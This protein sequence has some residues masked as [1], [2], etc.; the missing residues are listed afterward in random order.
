MDSL[1]LSTVVAFRLPCFGRTHGG[2]VSPPPGLGAAGDAF[3]EGAPNVGLCG[4]FEEFIIKKMVK[5][6][7]DQWLIDGF[8]MA[9]YG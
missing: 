9:N 4:L 7:M 1:Q 2:F 6:T 3:A 5:V 8:I